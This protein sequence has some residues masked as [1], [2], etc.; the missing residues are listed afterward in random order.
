MASV[1]SL[2]IDDHNKWTN[3]STVCL[4]TAVSVT[5]LSVSTVALLIFFPPSERFLRVNWN[6]YYCF[7]GVYYIWY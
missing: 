5:V 7:Y 2:F 4:A 6:S 3:R 1:N